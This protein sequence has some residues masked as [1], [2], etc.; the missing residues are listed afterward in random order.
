MFPR[1]GECTIASY[2][3]ISRLVGSCVQSECKRRNDFSEWQVRDGLGM[4][5]PRHFLTLTPSLSLICLLY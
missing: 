4:H 1:K 5:I 3:I 2:F